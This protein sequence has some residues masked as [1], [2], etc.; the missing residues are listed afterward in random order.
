MRLKAEG[1]MRAATLIA[2]RSGRP[3]ATKISNVEEAISSRHTSSPEVWVPSPPRLLHNFLARAPRLD[4]FGF[5]FV[6][7]RSFLAPS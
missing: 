3:L 2:R 1:K 4:S 7:V 5:G 6:R